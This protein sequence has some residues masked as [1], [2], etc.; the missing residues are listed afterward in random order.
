M[1]KTRVPRYRQD[2]SK[3]RD[4][5]QQIERDY[6]EEGRKSPDEAKRIVEDLKRHE[7]K[8]D[9]RDRERGR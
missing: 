9:N 3:V 6:R 5:Y 4:A 2:E 8:L 7:D 1:G